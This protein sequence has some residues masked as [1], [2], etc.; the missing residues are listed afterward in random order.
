[1]ADEQLGK[2][3]GQDLSKFRQE[4]TV[5]QDDIVK[6]TNQ[7]AAGMRSGAEGIV[8]SF[9]AARRGMDSLAKLSVDELATKKGQE[10]VEKSI[11]TIKGAQ[12]QSETKAYMDIPRLHPCT[13]LLIQLNRLSHGVPLVAMGRLISLKS[14]LCQK[15]W[16]IPEKV[17]TP[18][19]KRA[20]QVS[21][22]STLQ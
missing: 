15:P 12:I 14:S 17:C 6:A 20:D 22:E 21:P 11:S 18:T 1:M 3:S 4:L 9:T 13:S 16:L 10:A 5:F 2:L 7:V 8:N 19:N